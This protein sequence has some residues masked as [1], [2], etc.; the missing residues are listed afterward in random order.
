MA[1]KFEECLVAGG[2]ATPAAPHRQFRPIRAPETV[3]PERDEFGAVEIWKCDA[4]SKHACRPVEAHA[5][6]IFRALNLDELDQFVIDEKRQLGVTIP[7]KKRLRFALTIV[8]P[9]IPL[10]WVFRAGLMVVSDAPWRHVNISAD[11]VYRLRQQFPHH[12]HGHFGGQFAN[13]LA[14]SPIVP[15]WKT[16]D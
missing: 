9:S 1:T 13:E 15:K 14:E 2:F 11:P 6:G 7:Y 10:A 12:V 16:A 5:I 4:V 3:L 8:N